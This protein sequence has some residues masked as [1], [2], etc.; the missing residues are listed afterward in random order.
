[1]YHIVENPTTTASFIDGYSEINVKTAI[2]WLIRIS[3]PKSSAKF[4]KADMLA[5]GFLAS[6]IKTKELAVVAFLS[7]KWFVYLVNSRAFST[8]NSIFPSFNPLASGNL[9]KRDATSLALKKSKESFISKTIS[10]EGFD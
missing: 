5:A 7:S 6:E 8:D 9:D 3:D 10:V 4:I 1:M 2:A